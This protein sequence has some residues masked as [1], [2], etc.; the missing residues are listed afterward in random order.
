MIRSLRKRLRKLFLYLKHYRLIKGFCTKIQAK[1]LAHRICFASLGGAD[2]HFILKDKNNH[3]FAMARLALIDHDQKNTV[4]INR[5]DLHKRIAHET[6]AYTIGGLHDI[7]PKLLDAGKN[8]T[9]C[10]YIDGQNAL[11]ILRKDPSQGWKLL[12]TLLGL[13]EQLHQ[14]DITHL[15]ATL[16][17]IF[18]DQT[19]HSFKLVDFEY[20]AEET[21][22]LK[23]QKAYDYLRLIDYTLRFIPEARQEDFDAIL[24]LLKRFFPL[25][26]PITLTHLRPL[27]HKLQH[28][29]LGH[30]IAQEF[31]IT[32]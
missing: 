3:P 22:S 29:A 4:P 24:S 30:H 21:L 27:L 16:K 6:K 2:I 32:F 19:T 23:E 5:F 9:V 13:Y 18:W 26:E 17:N 14:H 25:N 7:T 20:Y 8:Y 11:Q 31:N 10:T 28:H 1:L 15:D 12:E